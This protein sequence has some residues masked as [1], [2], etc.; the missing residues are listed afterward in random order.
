MIQE[1]FNEMI[2]LLKEHER[3]FPF[4]SGLLLIFDSTVLVFSFFRNPS[5]G[6]SRK[7]ILEAYEAKFVLTRK[8]DADGLVL[9][10]LRT[11]THSH[12]C[13]SV[14]ITEIGTYTVYTDFCRSELIAATFTST[15]PEDPPVFSH[16]FINGELL[17]RERE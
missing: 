15:A 14:F 8:T 12:I 1:R 11:S 13:V 6:N 2:G 10:K 7:S 16:L 3:S 9:R 4:L 17:S 5:P